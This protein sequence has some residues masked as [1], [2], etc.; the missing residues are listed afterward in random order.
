VRGRDRLPGGEAE[1]GIDALA[2]Q[3]VGGIAEQGWGDL[4]GVHA[5][6]QRR[7]PRVVEGSGKAGVEPTG[8]LLHDVEARRQAGAPW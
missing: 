2:A 4:R 8:A 3:A 5:D 1:H 7:R 6:Q